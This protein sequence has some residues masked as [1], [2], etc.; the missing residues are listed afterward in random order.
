MLNTLTLK[1]IGIGLL[2]ATII[3][4]ILYVKNLYDD[5]TELK[6]KVILANGAIA[7]LNHKT[8]VEDTITVVVMDEFEK[9]NTVVY[10][11]SDYNG[12]V[13]TLWDLEG[14]NKDDEVN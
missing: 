12:T 13:D 3:G 2:L 9:L 14:W 4:G 6:T 11:I 1:L 5:N 10:D 8:K 7:G